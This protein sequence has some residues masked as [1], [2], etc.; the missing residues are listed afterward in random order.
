MGWGR[1]KGGRVQQAEGRQV[2]GRGQGTG[3][4]KTEGRGWDPRVRGRG[5]KRGEQEG[6]SRAMQSCKGLEQGVHLERI[7]QRTFWV[8]YSPEVLRGEEA[9]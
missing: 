8:L 2:E 4:R 5:V 9:P 1:A 7:I 6:G 3:S